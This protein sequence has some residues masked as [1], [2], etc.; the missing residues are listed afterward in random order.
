MFLPN[1]ICSFAV[2]LVLICCFICSSFVPLL[3]KSEKLR[4]GWSEDRKTILTCRKKAQ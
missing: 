2:Y 1:L 4:I 3:T